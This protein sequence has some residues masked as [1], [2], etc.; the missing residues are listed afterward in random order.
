[1]P[2]TE[3]IW[4][5]LHSVEFYHLLLHTPQQCSESDYSESPLLLNLSGMAGKSNCQFLSEL[6]LHLVSGTSQLDHLRTL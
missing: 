6:P 3:S 2:N 4:G 1:M 5:S